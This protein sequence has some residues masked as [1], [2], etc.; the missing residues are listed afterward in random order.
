MQVREETAKGGP[1]RETAYQT[2]CLVFKCC[3]IIETSHEE[4]VR[5]RINTTG[6]A[7]ERYAALIISLLDSN[8][9]LLSLLVETP[10]W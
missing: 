3:S 6:S 9:A 10:V 2:Y 4:V 8:M 7:I 1:K 5:L